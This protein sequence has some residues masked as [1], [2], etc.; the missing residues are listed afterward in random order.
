[1]NLQIDIDSYTFY[2]T[3]T[4]YSPAVPGNPLTWDS[5]YDY[6]GYDEECD[7]TCTCVEDCLEDGTVVEVSVNIDEYEEIIHDKVLDILH[8]MADDRE[9]YD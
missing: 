4:S 1:M 5:D 3:V 9:Y 6:Y 7:W 8:E 2:I